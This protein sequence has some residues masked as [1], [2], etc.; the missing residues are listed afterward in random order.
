MRQKLIAL[1][2]TRREVVHYL[3]FGAATTFVNWCVYGMLLR[4]FAISLTAAN[5]ISWIAAVTF[6]YFTNKI[7]V[8]ESRS[9]QPKLVLREAAAFFGARALSGVVEIAGMPLLLL[10][11]LDQAIFGIEGFA[12]KVLI[13]VIVIILNYVLSK[14]IVFRGK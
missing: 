2:K 7:W 12:A 13:G 14:L 5:V 10:L 11:G 4:F 1:Y 3:I 8:F 6:A 9:W